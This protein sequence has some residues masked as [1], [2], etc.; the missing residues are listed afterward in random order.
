MRAPERG[1][2]AVVAIVE[3]EREVR[4]GLRYLLGRDGR[5]RIAGAFARA[6][7]FLEWLETNPEP[8]LVLMDLNLPG[9][10]GIE[11]TRLLRSRRPDIMV[12]IL[13]IFEEGEKILSSIRAGAKGYIL[14]NTKPE[15]LA[16]QILSAREAG[17]PISPTVARLILEELQRGVP[18]DEGR[19]YDLTPREREVLR[20]IVD[21]F[22]CRELAERH[23]IADSTAKKHLLHIYQKLNVSSRA[24]IVRK[25]IE[26][27]LF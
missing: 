21:G 10:S 18:A 9:M 5:I 20:D 6:E 16:E 1:G 13:T 14:K 4:E 24:E 22:T 15:A 26:E 11:A 23:H 25:A 27:G 17:S 12:L 3:D 19:S 7:D 2:P 8:E